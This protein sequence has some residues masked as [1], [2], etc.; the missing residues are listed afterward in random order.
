MNKF[1]KGRVLSLK[2]VFKG[3]WLL[4]TG[5]PSAIVQTFIFLAFV[6]LGI[7]FGISTTEWIVQTVCCGMILTAEALNTAVEKIC[8]Y[9]QPNYDKRIGFIKDISAGAVGFAAC[10]GGIAVIIIYYKYFAQII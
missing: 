5:E 8:D 3:M 10:S 7:Y 1:V 4:I 6:A 2:Y 9:I